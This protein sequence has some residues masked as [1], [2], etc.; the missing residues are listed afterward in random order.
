MHQLKKLKS[1]LAKG[2]NHLIE[3]EQQRVWKGYE[4]VIFKKKSR[5]FKNLVVN[6]W[7]M[8]AVILDTSSL[9]G[10]AFFISTEENEILWDEDA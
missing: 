2:P 3:A 9:F 8:V 7:S 6:G 1:R 10:I 4:L 5:G